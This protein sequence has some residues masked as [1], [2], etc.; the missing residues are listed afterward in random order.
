[1]TKDLSD[2]DYA[3]LPISGY[4]RQY[5][6]RMLP[7]LAYYLDIYRRSLRRMAAAISRPLGEITMVDYGGG[8][9]FLS[10]TAKRMGVGKVL[11]VDFNPEACHTVEVLSREA[12]CGPDAVIQGDAA[13]LRQWCARQG[14]VPDA[15]LGMDV[16]E[17][18]YR[19]EDFFADLY[20]LSPNAY[21]LFTTGST[22]FNPILVRRLRRIMVADEL[23][24]GGQ[25]GFLELRKRHIISHFPHL[26]D[27]EAEMWAQCTRGLTYQDAL[28][29]V[30][31]GTPAPLDDPYNTCDPATG[32]WTERILPIQSYRSIVGLFG[33]RVSV[34]N[35]FYNARRRSL[36]GAA[37]WLLNLLLALDRLHLFAPFIYL[38]FKSSR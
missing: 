25:P 34:R 4:S 10:I 2:I 35:G 8:H 32:S 23:G 15:L 9:G 29:A 22:P 3:R 17:H 26:K 13:A 38:E 20:A 28:V 27:F 11:Y 30:E 18:I 31:A 24:H 5:I 12:G 37:S 1:M 36:K 6:L 16:I 33:A 19:L 14:V 7:S 21:M